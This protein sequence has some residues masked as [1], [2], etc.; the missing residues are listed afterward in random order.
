MRVYLVGMPG[1]GK[2][3][4]MRQLARHFSVC[5]YDLDAY[6]EQKNHATIP[7]LF[8]MSESHF[9]KLEH[10][11]LME[12]AAQVPYNAII[13]CG[14]GTP[15]FF[16][17]MDW[18]KLDGKVVYIAAT[19]DTLLRNV[20]YSYNK[21]PMLNEH[22]PNLEQRILNLYLE[23]KAIY[24]QANVILQAESLTLRT[25]AASITTFLKSN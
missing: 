25:F 19:I 7:E 3:Y 21:R 12:L 16:N 17:N 6:I 22:T 14:G 11:A 5:S 4:W 9:R 15:I 10:E 1:C 23:R 20:T 13:S 8:Q 24:E 2:S 18:M